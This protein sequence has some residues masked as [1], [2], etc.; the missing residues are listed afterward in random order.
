MSDDKIM[1]HEILEAVGKEPKTKK[2]VQILKNTD[3]SALRLILRGGLDRNIKW[4]LPPGTPPNFKPD[5]APK[6]LQLASIHQ[7]V[8][9]FYLFVQA[10]IDSGRC[11]DLKKAK[12]EQIFVQMLE[13]LHAKEAQL[14][15]DMKDQ[16]LNYK[17]LTPHLINE[18]FPGLIP[19]DGKWN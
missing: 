13:S 16:D 14:L 17:G 10:G 18:A 19:T 15:I 5:D 1:I 12:R 2:K 6:G 8:D 3:C 9:K 7:Q 11:K 4:I